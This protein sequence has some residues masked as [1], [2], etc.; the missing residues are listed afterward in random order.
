VRRI[1]PPWELIAIDNGSID[2]TGASLAGAQD[3]SS[4]PAT[5]VTNPRNLGF[6]PAINQGLRVARGEF[7]K[8]KPVEF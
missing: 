7:R 6:P 8:P 2:G 1:R 4:V 3:L 5:V